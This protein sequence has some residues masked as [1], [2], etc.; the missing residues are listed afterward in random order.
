MPENWGYHR[1][2]KGIKPVQVKKKSFEETVL[3][4]ARKTKPG[5]NHWGFRGVGKLDTEVSKAPGRVF[6]FRRNRVTESEKILAQRPEC[7]TQAKKRFAIAAV[8]VP[9]GHRA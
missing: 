4:G 5:G 6:L 9:C 3:A 8:K 7:V 2:A 1:R